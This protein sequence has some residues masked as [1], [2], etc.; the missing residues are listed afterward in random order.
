MRC[1]PSDFEVQQKWRWCCYD[2][3]TDGLRTDRQ[4]VNLVYFRVRRDF[5]FCERGTFSNWCEAR[6]LSLLFT[7]LSGFRPKRDH[8]VTTET[9][10]AH[11]D[12]YASGWVLLPW[13]PIN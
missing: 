12:Q 13:S 11:R 2:R 7:L 5:Y 10:V 9:D 6:L 4:T 1:M 3:K 8:H